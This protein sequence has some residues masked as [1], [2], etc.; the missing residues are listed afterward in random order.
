MKKRLK[1]IFNPVSGSGLSDKKLEMLIRDFKNHNYNVELLKTCGKGDAERFAAGADDTTS[2]IVTIGGDGTINEVVNGLQ[3][4]RIPIGIIPRGAANVL[5]KELGIPGNIKK[6][7]RVICKGKT[8][9]M[10]LGYDLKKYFTLMAGI[11]LDAEVVN[12]LDSARKG[13]ITFASYG[14]PIVKAISRY[15]FPDITIEVDGNLIARN[16]TCIFVSNVK[17]YVGPV[18]F[19]YLA[20][21]NDGKFDICIIKAKRKL[22]LP[23]FIFG[24][25]TRTLRSFSD[26]IYLR[27]K[28][29]KVTSKS[30]ALYQLDGDPGGSL[31]ARF[32]LKPNAVEFLAP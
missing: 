6:A 22:D 21:I 16:A 2:V 29:V 13:N 20:K 24:A 27:G 5:A 23:K 26:V 7:C 9:C 15:T 4:K 10:D 14:I 1:I 32:L 28:D 3:K 31:P 30:N 12:Y 25:L 18:K 19:A 11:G 8:I 17:G